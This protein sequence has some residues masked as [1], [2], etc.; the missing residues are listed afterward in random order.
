MFERKVK[1]IDRAN[2]NVVSFVRGPWFLED[3]L[4]KV[5]RYRCPPQAPHHKTKTRAAA[6]V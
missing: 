3:I 2:P 1:T 4:I 5:E 6:V